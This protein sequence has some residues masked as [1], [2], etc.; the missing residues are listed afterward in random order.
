[1]AF[2]VIANKSNESAIF[3][4]DRVVDRSVTLVPVV[5]SIADVVAL[6]AMPHKFKILADITTDE[7]GA[8]AIYDSQGV[9][10]VGKDPA[11][12]AE[13]GGSIVAGTTYQG[14]GLFLGQ[15]TDAAELTGIT[16][17][18][19]IYTSDTDAGIL[20]TEGTQFSN[21]QGAWWPIPASVVA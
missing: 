3:F 17:T 11:G 5:T 8:V 2:D 9:V 6:L 4:S 15:I 21:L 18:S 14:S 13:T 16:I 10:K 12:A 7:T 20:K 19:L 1:M